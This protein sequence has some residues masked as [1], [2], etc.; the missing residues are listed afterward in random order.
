ME[1][2]DKQFLENIFGVAPE[3]EDLQSATKLLIEWIG[4]LQSDPLEVEKVDIKTLKTR[5][6]YCKVFNLWSLKMDEVYGS[7]KD[8][9]DATMWSCENPAEWMKKYSDA[10]FYAWCDYDGGSLTWDEGLDLED[11][12][13]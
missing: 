1:K 12:N 8:R 2:I 6:D 13:E 11:K 9:N 4:E 5:D 10:V 3:L 7:T